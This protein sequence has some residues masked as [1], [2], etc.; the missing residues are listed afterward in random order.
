MTARSIF[1]CF[2]AYTF[3]LAFE[4]S[5]Q[6]S[7]W[8]TLDE[9]LKVSAERANQSLPRAVGEGLRQEKIKVSPGSIMIVGYT[10]LRP[11][12]A[13][14]ISYVNTHGR[15]DSIRSVCSI[16]ITRAAVDLGATV[17]YVLQSQRGDV[18]SSID[19][20]KRDCK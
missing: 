4:V 15:S 5:A 11:V 12:S 19:I 14:E 7:P 1:A 8:G 20:T 9:R 18:L 13:E 10:A 16:P 6:S 3:F 2:F 17:R